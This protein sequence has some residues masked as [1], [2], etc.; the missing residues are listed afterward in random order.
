[1]ERRRVV[2]TGLG[3]LCPIGTSLEKIEYSLRN[4]INGISEIQ[5]FDTSKSEVKMAAVIK[6]FDFEPYI[7]AKEMKRMD[8]TSAIAIVA[9]RM[10]LEDSGL[11]KEDIQDTLRVDVNLS[12][13][14]GGMY[15]IQE[16]TKKAFAK[17]MDRL[18]PFFIPKIISN[19][20][21]AR[22][23][24]D[25]GINGG[26]YCP[27]TACAGGTNAI[28][29]AFRNIRDGYIDVSFAGGTEA[30]INELGIGSFAALKALSTSQDPNRASIP[31]DKDRAGFVMG[32]GGAVLVLEELDHA[33]SRGADIYA[34]LIGYGVSSDAS[35]ITAPNEEG[36]WAAKAMEMA[37]ADG[38]ARPSDVTT[39]NAHGTS[40]QLN[41][42]SESRAIRRAFGDDA[43]KVLVSSTKSMTGHLLGAAGAVEGLIACL[44]IKK[45]FIAP[46]INIQNQDPQCQV[47][48]VKNKAIEREVN[49]V[50][51]NSLGFGGHNFSILLKKWEA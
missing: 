19:M 9:A 42:L 8:R 1:M 28:G 33:L 5:T 16:E 49:M 51:S 26:A 7:S 32:E 39:I 46:T 11:K 24:I 44:Q 12:S 48:L 27:V 50:M 14:I 22:V 15:T 40:T 17:G 2:I 38:G 21:A 23:S 41:E 25:L 10:A 34:E 4:G 37:M 35:H 43:D 36:K 6:D 45:G 18:S 30:T 29:D 47:N 31:F 13:G 3:S 20:S